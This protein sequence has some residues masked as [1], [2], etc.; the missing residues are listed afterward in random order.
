MNGGNI[1]VVQTVGTGCTYSTPRPVITIGD[2][3]NELLCIDV[4]APTVVP[5]P[6][7]GDS[8]ASPQAFACTLPAL[9]NAA[10]LGKPLAVRVKWP[11]DTT[12]Q[13]LAEL[14]GRIPTN[15][16]AVQT[17][18]AISEATVSYSCVNRTCDLTGA[19][20]VVWIKDCKGDQSSGGVLNNVNDPTATSNVINRRARA[21][22]R[23]GGSRIT[24]HGYFLG[25]SNITVGGQPCR[26]AVHDPSKPEELLTCVLPC[27][28]GDRD[29][30][31]PDAIK[32]ANVDDGHRSSSGWLAACLYPGVKDGIVGGHKYSK[33]DGKAQNNDPIAGWCASVNDGLQYLELDL[34]NVELVAGVVTQGRSDSDQW[35]TGMLIE[36]AGCA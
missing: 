3:V 21:C 29:E 25:A 19:P 24:V 23:E 7:C 15:V 12:V 14:A 9:T 22:P 10:L 34:G 1:L 6:S 18:N 2:G 33:I 32:L 31:I 26:D 11:Q 30:W 16:T 36:I 17:T 8:I 13:Y 4:R 20:R 28:A 35:V 27:P 5:D